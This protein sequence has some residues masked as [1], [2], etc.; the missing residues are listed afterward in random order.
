MPDG[1]AA[2]QE[3]REAAVE[4]A[5]LEQLSIS[6]DEAQV[7]NSGPRNGNSGGLAVATV[8]DAPQSAVAAGRALSGRGLD[9]MSCARQV[10]EGWLSPLVRQLMG[11]SQQRS[12][13]GHVIPARRL[14]WYARGPSEGPLD[15]TNSSSTMGV[16]LKPLLV[17]A[18]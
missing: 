7:T 10:I 3:P 5:S 14:G 17:V 16:G 2:Q 8:P 4:S 9:T 6:G 11:T 18:T 15:L 1:A 12:H 13:D